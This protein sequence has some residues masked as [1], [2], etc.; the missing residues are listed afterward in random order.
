[1]CGFDFLRFAWLSTRP[2]R[3]AV[4]QSNFGRS[5]DTSHATSQSP[6][7]GHALVWSRTS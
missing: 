5:L 2:W 3:Y 4:L 7:R 1:L 6:Y